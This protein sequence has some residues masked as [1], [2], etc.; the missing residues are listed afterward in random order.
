MY[1]HVY[2]PE[3]TIIPGCVIHS[4]YHVSHISP[5][6][7]SLLPSPPPPPPPSPPSPPTSLQGMVGLRAYAYLLEK[8]GQTSRANQLIKY[9]LNF[10][11]LWHKY[12][13]VRN[14]HI[15]EYTIPCSHRVQIVACIGYEYCMYVY[16]IFKHFR[17]IVHNI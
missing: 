2:I 7:F 5:L 17:C 1:F 6:S 9:D 14:T 13:L 15:H 11:E 12:S 10:T 8:K 16:A 4:V 3:S